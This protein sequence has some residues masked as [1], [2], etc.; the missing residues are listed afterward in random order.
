MKSEFLSHKDKHIA[1]VGGGVAGATA[2]IHFA[3]L[4]FKVSVIEKGVSLVNGPPICHLH[5]GGNLYREISEQQCLDLLTQ[6]IDTIR[7][8]PHSL[9]IRP[10]I[11]AVPHSDGG[12]PFAL[13]PRL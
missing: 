6:S 4:G 2:A 11:I 5:A 12:D 1:V 13:L 9:N 3:E 7:L 8:Y 10:T